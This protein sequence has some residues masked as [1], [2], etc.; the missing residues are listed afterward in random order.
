MNFDVEERF[1]GSGGCSPTP[2]TSADANLQGLIVRAQRGDLDAQGRLVRLYERRVAGLVRPIVHDEEAIKDIGQTVAIK[3]VRRLP[4]LRDPVRFESWL[5]SMARNAALDHVRRSRCRPI[6]VPD[7]YHAVEQAD[8]APDDRS[9]EIVEALRFA[10]RRCDGVS[11]RVLDQFIEG[12]TYDQI[13]HR[14]GLTVGA[15]KLRLHRLRLRL[16][17][18]VRRALSE[19]AATRLHPSLSTRRKT[20]HTLPNDSRARGASDEDLFGRTLKVKLSRWRRS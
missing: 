6:L 20:H 7:E 12:Y 17:Q 13:S 8:P 5:F 16:R 10:V 9:W 2:D 1:A 11:R 14:E 4:S 15:I 3:L 18:S 19:Q